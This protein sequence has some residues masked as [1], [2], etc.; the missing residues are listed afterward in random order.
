[1]IVAARWTCDGEIGQD[2]A[3]VSLV[4]LTCCH[5]H[6][7]VKGWAGRRNRRLP[8]KTRAELL[9][10]PAGND[11]FHNTSA[12]NHLPTPDM[13]VSGQTTRHQLLL[14]FLL[15]ILPLLTFFS[16]DCS[17]SP[18]SKHTHTVTTRSSAPPTTTARTHALSLVLLGWI[19]FLSPPVAM[20]VPAASPWL[21][22]ELGE[23][24]CSVVAPPPYSY[25]PN[26]SDLPRG[27]LLLFVR[28]ISNSPISL[29]SAWCHWKFLPASKTTSV[30]YILH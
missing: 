9:L 19:L 10:H 5:F 27:P 11:E 18:A 30:S 15:F 21:V 24:L 6:L 22:N 17:C 3:V 1:M 16:S 14:T 8:S 2:Q 29:I 12:S 7:I 20:M 13:T 4:I 28:L 25:D 26:G 23:A